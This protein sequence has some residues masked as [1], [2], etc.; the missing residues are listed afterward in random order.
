MDLCALASLIILLGFLWGPIKSL[1]KLGQVSYEWARSL[2]KDTIEIIEEADPGGKQTE[3]LKMAVCFSRLAVFV[4]I[5]DGEMTQDEFNAILSFFKQRGADDQFLMFVSRIVKD[6]TGRKEEYETT[7][8]I[9]NEMAAGDKE[10]KL[11]LCAA[12][13]QIAAADG[14][15]DKI[16]LNLIWDVMDRLGFTEPERIE[17]LKRVIDVGD[18]KD[19]KSEAFATLGLDENASQSDIRDS[20]RRLAQQYH[21]DKVATLGPEF[22]ALANEKFMRIKNAY[23]LLREGETV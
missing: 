6:V 17:F 4:S 1:F 11:Y 22:T 16:E 13:L 18:N 15:L 8:A 5:A 14:N 3:R 20:F 19:P 7:L 9:V 12:L 2:G 10:I 23:D 21:P